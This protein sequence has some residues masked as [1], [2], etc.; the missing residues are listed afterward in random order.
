M[1]VPAAPPV[2]PDDGAITATISAATAAGSELTLE[3]ADPPTAHAKAVAQYRLAV[4]TQWPQGPIERITNA[5]GDQLGGAWPELTPEPLT[6]V[7]PP[8]VPPATPGLLTVRVAYIDP[9]GRMGAITVTT[10]S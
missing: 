4:W 1:H 7:V 5:D 2:A 6:I 8:P 3:I 9:V 10:V